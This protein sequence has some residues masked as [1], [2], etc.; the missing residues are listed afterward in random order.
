MSYRIKLP[1]GE[2]LTGR[3][4]RRGNSIFINM[5]F[6]SNL[7][8]AEGNM[9][10]ALGPLQ[11]LANVNDRIKSDLTVCK[12]AFFLIFD[13]TPPFPAHC[14]RLRGSSPI[15]QYA[16]CHSDSAGCRIDTCL[17]GQATYFGLRSCGVGAYIQLYSFGSSVCNVCS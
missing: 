11:D 7:V 4:W 14:C 9:G 8:H 13:L 17:R 6:R 2:W 12:R 3:S 15:Q 5:P 16:C 1:N 10:E